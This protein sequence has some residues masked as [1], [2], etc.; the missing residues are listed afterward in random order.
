MSKKV[1]MSIFVLLTQPLVSNAKEANTC[2]PTS[3][4]E[5]VKCVD[6]GSLESQIIKQKL[7]AA[8]ELEN[9][10]SQFVNPDLDA[11]TLRK[12]GD[13]SE[14]T[15]S[16]L[17]NF[18]IGGK[19]SALKAEA[20]AEKDKVIAEAD[21]SK[22][23]FRLGLIKQL[24]RLSQLRSEIQIEEESISTFNKIIGQFSRRAA[25]T[26][27]Q[28]VS[29]SIFK[30]AIS[31]HQLSLTELKNLEQEILSGL[32][33]LS[34][35][36][37]EQ[38]IKNLPAKKNTWPKIESLTTSLKQS[39]HLRFAEAELQLAK[40]QK[41]K[42]VSESFPDLKIGPVIKNQKDGSLNENFAGIGLSM[43]LPIFSLN[44]SAR[45]YQSKKVLEAEL[46]LQ[47]EQKKL[48]VMKAQLVSKY[49]NLVTSLKNSP[50]KK[51]MDD[52][53]AKIERL[54]FGGLVSGSLVI[55]A[56][57]QL[58]DLEQKRNQAELEAIEAI[59]Q[60]YIIDNAFDGVVL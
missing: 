28:E 7:E 47:N 50:D 43:P 3:Y 24:Y 36:S 4:D 17:F 49:N 33:R 13:K 40:S 11:E 55:E 15:A 37:A 34:N 39:P 10:A 45:A 2:Q 16:L 53:H 32:V 44:G 22:A 27:E 19:R 6:S 60:L 41:E 52:R 38:I 5:L 12:D 9:A 30:M 31:D 56:H 48:E 54:F 58:F 29:V 8:A 20:R 51:V 26:P 14:T 57:R 18:S 46:T 21:L 59:G 35:L 42:A 1:F 23:S 25:L